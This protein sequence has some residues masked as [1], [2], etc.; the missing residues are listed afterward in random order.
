MNKFQYL[1]T[2]HSR[3]LLL[4]DQNQVIKSV[5]IPRYNRILINKIQKLFR[6]KFLHIQQPTEGVLVARN[7]TM[8]KGNY[9]SLQQVGIASMILSLLL[10]SINFLWVP[11][12]V[13]PI[14]IIISLWVQSLMIEAA[15]NLW[16]E[17]R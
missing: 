2:N 11:V 15:L 9:I 7:I 14:L 6:V 4:K 13:L 5:E 12:L 10:L 16:A 17:L 3:Y 1:P 8:K